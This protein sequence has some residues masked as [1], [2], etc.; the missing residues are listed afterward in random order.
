MRESTIDLFYN[1]LSSLVISETVSKLNDSIEISKE[2]LKQL[3]TEKNLTLTQVLNRV[4]NN[5]SISNNNNSSTQPK[6]ISTSLSAK[7]SQ[8]RFDSFQS[9]QQHQPH[10]QQPQMHFL[11]NQHHLHPREFQHNGGSA[12]SHLNH[13]HSQSYF[14]P[15]DDDYSLSLAM[16]KASHGSMRIPLPLAHQIQPQQL[17]QQHLHNKLIN[18]DRH[19]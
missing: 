15:S 12:H 7:S 1:T 4:K 8:F 19:G 6:K 11:H 9:L 16:S 14:P 13:H 10:H 3:K 5:N 2:H 17:Q 18:Y